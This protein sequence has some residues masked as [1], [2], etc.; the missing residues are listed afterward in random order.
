MSDMAVVLATTNA[1]KVAEF[2]RLR[3]RMLGHGIGAWRSLAELGAVLD[4]DECGESLAANALLK[5]RAAAAA[6]GMP[7]LAD[8]TGLFVDALQGAPGVRSARYAGPAATAASNRQRLLAELERVLGPGAPDEAR[9]ATAVFRCHLTWVDADGAVIAESEGCCR[10]RIVTAARGGGGFGYDTLF[11]LP[12][13]HCT[14]AELSP[15]A[16]DLLGHRGR[17]FYRLART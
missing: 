10:G 17:A 5:A 4:V 1:N 13:H 11:E 12:E 15:L 16:V 9:P 2:E 3:A 14:L 7:A 8:D 6:T